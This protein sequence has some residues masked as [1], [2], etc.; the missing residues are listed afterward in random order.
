MLISF[1]I[2]VLLSN[3]LIKVSKITEQQQFTLESFWKMVLNRSR[4]SRPNRFGVKR[5]TRNINGGYIRVID[6]IKRFA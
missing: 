4:F 1:R 2:L 6:T 5:K 3:T